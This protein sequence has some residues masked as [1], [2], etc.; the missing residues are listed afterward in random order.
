MGLRLLRRECR[1]VFADGANQDRRQQKLCGV[2]AL[3]DRARDYAVEFSALAGV[4]RSS[5]RGDGGQCGRAEACVQ[6]VWLRAGHRKSVQRGGIPGRAV[7]RAI[8]RIQKSG[9]T[10]CPSPYSGRHLDRQHRSGQ[11]RGRRSG[12]GAEEIGVGVGRER[13]VRGAGGR[14][15]GA[16]GGNVCQFEADQCGPELHRGQAIYRDERG[17]RPIRGAGRRE[18][19]HTRVR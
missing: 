2:R 11:S 1:E 9:R 12:E 16:G 18:N 6:C 10:H 4:P 5:P 13:S 17:A 3:G 8:G 15:P 14:R 19:A 7:S